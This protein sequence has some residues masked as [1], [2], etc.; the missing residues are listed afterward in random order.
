AFLHA[1][2][3]HADSIAFYRRMGFEVRAPMTYTILA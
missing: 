3:D 1:F 2:A